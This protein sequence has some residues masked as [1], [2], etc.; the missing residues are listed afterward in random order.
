MVGAVLVRGGRVV[1]EGY[2]HRDGA[3]HAEIDCLRKVGFDA[4]GCDMY[5]TLEP[6][7]TKGRTGACSDAIIASG[8]SRVVVGCK[9]VNPAHSGRAE[10]VFAARGIKT[11]FGVLERECFEL[12]FIFNKNITSGESLLAVKYASTSDGFITRKRGERAQI[13]GEAA[14]RDAMKWRRLFQSIGVGFGT[15]VA[16]NPSLT[17]RDESGIVIGCGARLIFDGALRCADLPGLSRFNVF[18]DEFRERTRVVCGADASAEREFALASR[19]VSVM[20]V[21]A[22]S[23]A[24][25]W[26]E[27]KRR[28]FAERICSLYVEGGAGVF[29]SVCEGRAADYV[30]EYVSEISFGEGLPAFDKKYFSID[31]VERA[32]FGCDKFARGYPIWTQ[33]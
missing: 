29:A 5:V 15:L 8:V 31:A 21:N 10:K 4:R 28:L 33:K 22:R 7:T 16:D 13:T 1:A 26:A 3:A 24:D 32:D 27:L 6:C 11:R 14:R 18:S 30:F 19:G 12:N 25:F 2:H 20:R 17:V 23:K 9:D